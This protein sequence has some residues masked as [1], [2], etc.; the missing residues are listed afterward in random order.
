MVRKTHKTKNDSLSGRCVDRNTLLMREV[1]GEWADFE[2]PG[3]QKKTKLNKKK[4]SLS[5]ET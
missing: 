2:A 1:R 5:D 3:L 4:R